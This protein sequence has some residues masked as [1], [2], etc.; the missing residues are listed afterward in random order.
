MPITRLTRRRPQPAAQSDAPAQPAAPTTGER[1]R[2]ELL[3]PAQAAA[4]LS[5]QAKVLE[6]WRGTGGGPAFVRLSSKTIRYR[7]DDIDDFVAG[8]IRASTAAAAT[9]RPPRQMSFGCS[10]A[11]AIP[12]PG[13]PRPDGGACRLWRQPK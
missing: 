11:G 3:T 4:I 2:A 1:G 8:R 6:R 13:R 12:Q 5:V 7:R 10:R 9:G